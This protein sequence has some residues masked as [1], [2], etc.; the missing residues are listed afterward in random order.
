MGLNFKRGRIPNSIKR[1][2]ERMVDKYGLLAYHYE[3]YNCA[4]DRN[5]P[6][7]ARGYQAIDCIV[8]VLKERGL[9]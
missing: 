9:W 7:C 5:Y 3:C 4:F 2:A 6:D 1:Y 8:K